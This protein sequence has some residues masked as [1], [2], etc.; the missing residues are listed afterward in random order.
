[1]NV[2]KQ[3][4]ANTNSDVDVLE[5]VPFEI[6]KNDRY[7]FNYLYESNN[8]FGRNQITNV[9]KIAAFYN[10]KKLFDP[11]NPSQMLGCCQ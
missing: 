3:M 4:W 9:S 7:F 2:N 5:L 6:M 10:N 11:R 8:T 1:M